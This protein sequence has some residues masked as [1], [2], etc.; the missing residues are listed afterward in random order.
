VPLGASSRPAARNF[1]IRQ[2]AGRIRCF[3]GVLVAQPFGDQKAIGGDAQGRMM[4][5]ATPAPA[6]IIGQAKF[7]LEILIVTFNAPTHLGHRHKTFERGVGGQR[8]QD[9]FVG[10]ALPFGPFDQEP[11]FI[12]QLGPPVIPVRRPNTHRSK[13]RRQVG[14]AAGPPVDESIVRGG[15]THRQRLH[16]D[17]L[18]IGIAAQQARF[19]PNAAPGFGGQG[20]L[21]GRP[22]TGCSLH[23]DCGRY[24]FLVAIARFD[25]PPSHGDWLDASKLGTHHGRAGSAGPLEEMGEYVVIRRRYERTGAEVTRPSFL[26]A[27]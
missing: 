14:V 23:A 10:F 9:V 16:A 13:T 17:W 12:P 19:A 5:E 1:R 4:V 20:L 25:L 21:A 15:Q 6:L 24:D 11:L 3:F 2:V 22:D 26:R 18:V 8:G 7:L 27:D